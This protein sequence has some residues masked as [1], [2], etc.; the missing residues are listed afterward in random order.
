M[1]SDSASTR[2]KLMFVV[3]GT[4]RSRAPFTAVLR[5]RREHAASR[6]DRAARQPRALRRP[7]TA[8]HAPPRRRSR[9]APGTFSV[10]RAA[11]SLL[12][13][14][15]H[16][17]DE[18]RAPAHPQRARALRPVELVRGDRQ[19]IHAERARRRRRSLP[20]D[21]TASVWTSAPRACATS[22]IAA[23]GC[24]VPTL[25]VRVHHRHDRR[26]V[27]DAR[28]ARRRERRR[29]TGSSGRT[30]NVQPRRASARAVLQHR[31]VLDRADHDLAAPGGFERLGGAPQGEVV[32]SRCPPPVNTTSDGVA[33]DQAPPPARARRRARPSP[34]ARSV[35]ARG[36]A[37][38]VAHGR[39][40][41]PPTTSGAR[42]VVAL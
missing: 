27:R 4:R 31:L 3:F 12:P 39:A 16:L 23:T 17:R 36:V 7:A 2:S 5:S 38:Q 1:S 19:Q 14:A 35:H 6:A 9:R 10:P 22:A 37:E 11:D 24:I 21:C 13:S 33:A 40:S 30:V 28:R 18:P 41:W 8:Q 32:G 15:G 29:P 25:V 20:A 42:G 26:P 34:A